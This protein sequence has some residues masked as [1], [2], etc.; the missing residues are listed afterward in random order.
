[1]KKG[2]SGF[3]FFASCTHCVVV[4]NIAIIGI[5]FS[6][7]TVVED[8]NGLLRKNMILYSGTFIMLTERMFQMGW[9]SDVFCVKMTRFLWTPLQNSTN[10]WAK[11]ILSTIKNTDVPIV[12]LARK[13]PEIYFATKNFNTHLCHTM[14][15]II[16]QRNFSMKTPRTGT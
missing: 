16:V 1:M 5:L 14:P 13:V 12:D 4:S 15:V 7:F 10:T 3:E 8:V 6:F 9:K 2:P 11:N